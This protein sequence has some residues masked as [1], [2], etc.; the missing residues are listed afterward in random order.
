MKLSIVIPAFNEEKTVS[1]VVEKLLTLKIENVSM[2]IIVV[3]DGSTDGTLS[4]LTNLQKKHKGFILLHHEENTGKGSAIRTAIGKA[5]GEYILIQDAD[6]EYNPQ[7]IKKLLLPVQE[8]RAAV[9][10]GTRLKRLPNFRKDER[11]VTFFSHYLG[12]KS[13]S[14]LTS[15]LFGQW[16]T[17]ME[18]GYKLFPKRVALQLSL[19]AK[20]FEFEPEITA[21]ILKQG[22]KILE[23]S[24]STNPRKQ[25]EGKKLVAMKDGPVAL[26]TLLKYRF[27]N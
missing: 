21:K 8:E 18:T 16:I 10:Y 13:L 11:T 17:D 4:I 1:S 15:I 3:D 2:E 22:Y 24:I 23:V 25:S 27:V 12:N 14:L 7:E 20:S 19:K 6:S 26:W 5:T 9:V